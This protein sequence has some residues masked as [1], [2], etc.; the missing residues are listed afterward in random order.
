MSSKI[1]P[2]KIWS[3]LS[4]AVIVSSPTRVARCERIYFYGDSPTLWLV[5]VAEVNAEGWVGNSWRVNQQTV[6]SIQIGTCSLW[7]IDCWLLSRS[8]VSFDETLHFCR[9][10]ES[11]GW[12]GLQG[13][14]HIVGIDG[15]GSW[16]IKSS[17]VA[18]SSWVNTG[19]W[20]AWWCRR[21]WRSYWCRCNWCRCGCVINTDWRLSWAAPVVLDSAADAASWVGQSSITSLTSQNEAISTSR[22]AHSICISWVSISGAGK[23]LGGWFASFARARAGNTSWV[24]IKILSCSAIDRFKYKLLA[25]SIGIFVVTS[26]AGASIDLWIEN[27]VERTSGTASLIHELVW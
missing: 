11:E 10:W 2:V 21:S 12:I 16:L 25:Y 23:T 26:G 22:L 27:C 8:K 5:V 9:S 18:D 1:N 7:A 19:S 14:E 3:S 17:Q 4:W 24:A 15:S 13:N 6:E 20:I